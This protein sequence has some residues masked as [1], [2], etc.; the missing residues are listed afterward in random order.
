[1]SVLIMS[2]LNMPVLNM[3]ILHMPVRNMS[4]LHNAVCLE[5][6]AISMTQRLI[7]QQM[8]AEKAAIREIK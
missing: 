6:L 2:V 4:V 5:K 8:R 1:M 3:S 7:E